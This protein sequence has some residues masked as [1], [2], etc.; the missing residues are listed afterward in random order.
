MK[1]PQE[2][3]SP[4]HLERGPRTPPR[5][6]SCLPGTVCGFQA[7]ELNRSPSKAE[8]LLKPP[9]RRRL[10]FPG[11]HA[12]AA[13]VAIKWREGKAPKPVS[14]T[15]SEASAG[16]RQAS[17]FISGFTGTAGILLQVK[18]SQ[19]NTKI[20]PQRACCFRVT[21]IKKLLN[22]TSSFTTFSFFLLLIKS[23]RSVC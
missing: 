1:N 4:R 8:W 9:V 13:I 7:L 15:S 18:L 19:K 17:G 12:G 16:D 10:Y 3:R 23:P 21:T 20:C 2:L 14:G 11:S 6:Q 5:H 22:E